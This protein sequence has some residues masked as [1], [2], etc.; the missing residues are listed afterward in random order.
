MIKKIILAKPRGACAGVDRAVQTVERVLELYGKPV[1]IK[2]EIVHNKVIVEDLAQKGAITVDNL[3][4]I[5]EGSVV[6]FSAHGSRPEEYREAQKRGLKVVDATCPLV[7]KVHLEVGRFIKKGYKIIYIGQKEHI[8]G[9][10]VVAEG[11]ELGEKIPIVETVED[12]DNLSGFES[13]EKL[14]YLNQTT[15]N[16]SEV[17]KVVQALKSKFAQIADPLS[18]DICYATTNRQ[19]AV[20]EL[21]KQSDVVLVV[22]SKTS[23][24]SKKMVE[25]VKEI[26]VNGYLVDCLEDIDF[27][28]FEG[29]NVLGLS[30]GASAPEY[31]VAEIV[32]YFKNLG[33][34]TKELIVMEEKIKFKLPIFP[35][36]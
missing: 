27:D 13:A 14:I 24:N 1:Y 26:G 20:V 11:L 36:V 23:S 7:T 15:L 33:V 29:K 17:E 3:Q 30:A 9:V 22:G 2:H 4:E 6:V 18:S 10:G 32:K 5:P 19:K 34:N 28:W 21:A 12:V 16:L 25:R 31:K 8:E 35:T